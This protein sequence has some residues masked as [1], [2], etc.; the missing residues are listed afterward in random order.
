MPSLHSAF[1]LFVPAFFLPRIKPLWLKAL[2]LCFPIMMLTSLVYFGEHWVIDGLIG[3]L[4]VGLSFWFWGWF[5]RR[6]LRVRAARA[7]LFLATPIPT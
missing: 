5:E 1:S 3:W 6:Q 7:R 2:V 4:L